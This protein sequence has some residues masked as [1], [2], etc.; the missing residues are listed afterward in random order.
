MPKE[1]LVRDAPVSTPSRAAERLAM[2]DQPVIHHRVS[3][4]A[5]LAGVVV[6]LSIQLLLNLLGIGVGA[7]TITPTEGNNPGA[8]LA[9][10]AGIWFVVSALIS[11]YAGGWASGRLAG[12]VGRK[13]GMIHGFA[14]WSLTTLLTFYLLT[15]TVGGILGGAASLLHKT[16]SLTGQSATAAAPMLGNLASEA[17]GV[18]PDEIR[19]QAGDVASDPHFQAFATDMVKNGQPTAEDRNNLVQLVAQKQNISP[20]QADAEVSGWQQKF[21]D[22]KQQ[23]IAKAQEAGDTAAAGVT[24]AALWSFLALLLGAVAATLGGRMGAAMLHKYRRQDV[25]EFID[26]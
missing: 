11:L 16:A 23:A 3:W 19:Q 1:F 6:A 12:T 13:D 8:G 4:G 7:S 2:P 17:T 10:G 15:T 18:T 21:A 9:I 26:N 22:A 14:T 20:Q 5:I 25:S 24:R